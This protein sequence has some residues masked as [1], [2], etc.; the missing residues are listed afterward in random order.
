MIAA[1]LL[2][3]V[4]TWLHMVIF[5]ETK[6]GHA[7]HPVLK[8]SQLALPAIAVIGVFRERL[9]RFWKR[10]AHHLRAVPL[11]LVVGLVI[12]A[13]GPVLL[14]SPLGDLVRAQSGRLSEAVHAIGVVSWFWG[15]ATILSVVHS[16][17]EEYYWRWFVF[18]N[19]MRVVQPITAHIL[20]AVLF[21][22][23]HIIVLSVFF[24]MGLSLLLSAMVGIGGLIFSW[25]YRRQDSI[26]GAWV[27]H[28]LA[29]F[30]IMAIGWHVTNGFQG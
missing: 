10:W 17:M 6:L 28:M 22:G 14:V 23:Y 20:A 9:P 15:F 5:A 2:P 27:A 19:L 26:A 1:A 8:F 13:M 21:T 25:L 11:G 30:G 7:L 12:I 24:P 29:D 3:I 16:A 18:G 4:G